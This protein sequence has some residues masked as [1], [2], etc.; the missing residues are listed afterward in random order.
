MGAAASLA[1]ASWS[2]GAAPAA[3]A[4]DAVHAALSPDT[5]RVA[6]GGSFTLEL[7]IESPGKHFNAYDAVV[8]FDTTVV[9][10]VPATDPR[11]DEGDL[12]TGACGNTF[13]RFAARADS[14]TI[15]HVILCGGVSLEGPGTLHHLH[16]RAGPEGGTTVVHLR[17]VQFYDAGLY[18]RPATS[19]GA[20]VIVTKA[21]PEHDRWTGLRVRPLLP[22][23]AP[24]NGDAE[25]P[26]AC[27]RYQG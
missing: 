8:A 26:S 27:W 9:E 22:V 11:D 7:R 15:S 20:V 25:M 1:F 24:L 18:V 23:A 3:D 19:R 4:P 12:M 17:R 14:M 13:H 5:V 21:K 6:P 10:F 2:F 16:F